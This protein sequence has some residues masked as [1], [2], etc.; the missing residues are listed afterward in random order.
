MNGPKWLIMFLSALLLT[1]V[2]W[3]AVNIAVD[4]FGVFGDA[5]LTWD[6][7]SQTLNPRV[8]KTTYL[9]SH[10]DEYDSY[11][12][13]SSSA[14]SYLP[15]TLEK[16]RDGS[17]YN[18]FHY[19]AD[20]AYDK[21]LVSWL[22]END[23]VRHIILVLGINEADSEYT[24]TSLTDMAHY[25]V[26]GES[27]V[28]YYFK[29]LF[30]G[31][32]FSMEKIT[33]LKDDTEMPQAF[34]VFNP[35][36]GTYD[37]RVRDVE[38]I[39]S[40]DSYL[41]KNGGD[42]KAYEWTRELKYVE[43]CVQ[44]VGE[45]RDMC[46]EAEVELTVILSPV[47][48]EQLMG[49]TDESLNDYF[50]KLGEVV[51]YW[52]FSIS[53]VSFDERYFYDTTHTRNATGDMVLARVFGDEDVYFPDNFG[54]Y[55]ENKASICAEE[56]KILAESVSVEDYTANVPVLLYHH[57]DPNVPEDA[58]TLHPDTFAAQMML[59]YTNGYTPV[60]FDQITAYV[61]KGE[62]LPASPVIITFDDGYLSNYEY[63][64]PILKE[65]GWKA[66]IFVIG[67]SVGHYEYYKDTQYPLKPHFG[68][69]EIREM[70]DSGLISIHSHTY[71][72]HQ[73]GPYEETDLARETILPLAGESERDYI[74]ALRA[75]IEKQNVLFIDHGLDSA[76]V[77]SYP[78]G[79]FEKIS[80]VILRECGYKVTLCSD[81]TRVN[82]LVCG[83]PQSLIDLGRMNI[84]DYV[85][86]ED[87]L[88][89]CA[90]VTAQK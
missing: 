25:S 26:T 42:F 24:G 64:F 44:T 48:A 74:E 12:V 45:I 13:G 62:A 21:E 7:Y 28:S 66:S 31:L 1:F 43:K 33:S 88:A 32:S 67:S 73:W 17:Y 57:L 72:M 69:T 39:G 70:V 59:L 14:A 9:A 77:L 89:Y 4:P 8:G 27:A 80:D 47:S 49:Y 46:D 90:G 40:L 29:Y 3:G 71:D 83:L 22:I 19:G 35:Y 34:D 23:D 2:V 18:M 20:I 53:S 41:K 76:K 38:S 5:L 79:K 51:D 61:E 82:T 68:E 16:Y 56:L 58:M 86:D 15:K 10:F 50:T 63:A 30:A 65:Y 85:T 6:S 55:L 84:G 60:S 87:I 52:N 54:V 75:D 78:E 11:V 81:Q 36:D 37:K